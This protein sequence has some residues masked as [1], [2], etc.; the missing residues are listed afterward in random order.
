MLLR[1]AS[2]CFEDVQRYI[3]VRMGKC[4]GVYTLYQSPFY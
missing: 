1:S 4:I 2:I 3:K